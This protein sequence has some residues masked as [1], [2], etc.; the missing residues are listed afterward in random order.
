MEE[1]QEE[2]EDCHGTGIVKEADGTNHTCWKCLQE[3]KLS[4]HT[5]NLK[6]NNIKI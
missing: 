2:C 5:R 3:G 1:N 4:Q 6:D